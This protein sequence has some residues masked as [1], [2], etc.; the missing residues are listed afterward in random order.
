MVEHTSSTSRGLP[1]RR[2]ALKALGGAVA[3]GGAVMASSTV[4]APPAAA[5]GHGT[6]RI[7]DDLKPGGALD[8]FAAELATKD[9]WSGSLLVTHRGR[10]VLSRSHGFANRQTGVRNRPDTRF[11]V[12]SLTKMFTGVAIHQLAQQGKVDYGEKLG[13]YLEGLPAKTADKV[14]LHHL[15]THTSGLG[16]YYSIPGYPEESKGWS[17][18]EE[19]FNGTMEY[20]RRAGSD[21]AFEP[22]TRNAY[23]NTGYVLLGAIVAAVSDRSYYSYIAE[24]VFKAAD[25]R[26]SAFHTKPEWRADPRI[27]HP[28]YKKEGQTGWTDGLKEHAYIGLPPGNSFGTCADMER[29]AHALL[30]NKLMEAPYTRLMLGA[31]LPPLGGETRSGGQASEPSPLGFLGYGSLA[32]LDHGQWIHGHGGG[33]T[34]GHSANIDIFP[35]T[36]WVVVVL[37][38]YADKA[39]SPLANLARRLIVQH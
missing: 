36:D 12:A 29:F 33:S 25:M 18:A 8:R 6:A 13:A 19:V 27:A 38:G 10:T 16:N 17:S 24:H 1:S 2:T 3:S 23:S 31:K 7:P 14:T 34:I 5:H 37:S 4:A 22:G 20:I 15:L 30:E 39:S 9:E 32:I 21:L 28:Y 35:D 26:D 11:A